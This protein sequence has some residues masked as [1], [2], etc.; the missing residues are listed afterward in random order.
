MLKSLTY[1]QSLSLNT[2]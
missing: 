1:I 2:F